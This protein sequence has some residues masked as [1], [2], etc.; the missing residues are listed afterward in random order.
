MPKNVS[1]HFHA[2]S[3][4]EYDDL[5]GAR[6]TN[7]QLAEE[8]DELYDFMVAGPLPRAFRATVGVSDLQTISL[9]LGRDH[10][11]G[12]LHIK[13]Q[14]F[15]TVASIPS[16]V[17]DGEWTPARRYSQILVRHNLSRVALT[18]GYFIA[19]PKIDRIDVLSQLTAL[20]TADEL[21]R[22]QGSVQDFLNS[23]K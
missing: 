4:Q 2:V 14:D 19:R 21:G 8:N 6:V 11:V 3:R 15:R 12:S 16:H 18:S 7:E 22:I 17:R 13:D 1:E 23:I 5:F 9:R 10:L 20:H